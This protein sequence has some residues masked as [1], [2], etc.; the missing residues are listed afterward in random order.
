MDDASNY[1]LEETMGNAFNYHHENREDY[2]ATGNLKVEEQSPQPDERI[3]LMTSPSPSPGDPKAATEMG[4]SGGDEDIDY[5][6]SSDEEPL[7]KQSR[8]RILSHTRLPESTINTRSPSP[9]PEPEIL[10]HS[11]RTEMT[12]R[13]K[14]APVV[15]NDGQDMDP[16]TPYA[17]AVP[18][19]IND[20]LSFKLPTYEATYFISDDGCP[21]A[22]VS[23][24]HM[25]REEILLCPDHSI[26]E[27]YLITQIFMPTHEV[28]ANP[29]PEPRIALLNFH[30]IALMVIKAYVNF[31]EGDQLSGQLYRSQ[32]FKDDSSR[33]IV[34]DARNADTDQIFFT[35][36]DTWRIGNREMVRKNYG[37]IRGVQEFCDIAL[38]IIYYIKEHGLLAAKES[39]R[40][41]RSDKGKKRGPRKV[42]QAAGTTKS[43]KELKINELQ[44]RK[45]VE[46][47]DSKHTATKRIALQAMNV[48]QPR[49]KFK[50]TKAQGTSKAR[51]QSRPIQKK[52]SLGISVI[53]N[54][55]KK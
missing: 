30:T 36:M 19:N 35:A 44:P 22:K 1:R 52:K 7:M 51:S 29:D 54:K 27:F 18:A 10:D 25:V 5:M 41:E 46:Q 26:Q 20:P 31:E 8:R 42:E 17:S 37:L 43:S 24:P 15:S 9:A 50:A 32:K 23:L 34:R 48:S 45:A 6:A 47:G 4:G 39:V 3:V 33:S 14:K 28:L 40:K 38:D 21:S 53:P 16:L 12:A 13:K 55:R 11:D 2:A 49:K